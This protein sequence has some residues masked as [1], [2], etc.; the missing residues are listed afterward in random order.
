MSELWP[1]FGLM[2]RTPDLELRALREAD[3]LILAEQLS[4]DVELDP[5]LP[6]FALGEE[7]LVR[8]TVPLQSYW[9]AYAG[10]TVENWNLPFGVWHGE[11]LIG[12]Q[13]L[14]GEQFLV[15]RV[16]DTSSHLLMEW[17]GK[18]L[19][20]QMRRAVL[21]L[22]FG[23]LGAEW[24]VSSAWMDNAASL[25]VSRAV[26]YELNGISRHVYEGQVGVFQHVLLTRERWEAGDGGTGITVRGFES[27]RPM[28]GLDPV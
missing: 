5:T 3:A 6:R 17:R 25:G 27:C 9:R 1:L 22:G 21:A 2:I 7:R 14:E 24:A 16:V 18:G 26:G 13:S 4:P 23:E 11:T 20:K 15:K 19:G 10:W 8:A 12:S 28:F